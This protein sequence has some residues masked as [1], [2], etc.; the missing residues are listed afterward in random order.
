[1]FEVLLGRLFYPVGKFDN[2][3]VMPFLKGDANTG[4]STVLNLIRSMFPAGSVGVITASQEAK[5]GLESRACT[6][7]VWC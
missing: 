7:S 3:Q 2:W 1:M 5:F 6:R 4:K